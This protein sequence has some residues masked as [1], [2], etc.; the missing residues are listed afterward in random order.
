MEIKPDTIHITASAKVEIQARRADLFIAVRGS[1]VVGGNEAMKKAKEVSALVDEL[2]GAGIKAE[3]IH[4]EGVS[5]ET[6]SGVLLKSSSATYRLR[7]RCEDLEK[8]PETLDIVSAQKNAALERVA[9]KYN[10]EGARGRGLESAL[11]AAKL[12]AQKVA[13]ALGVTLLGVYSFNENAFDE[14]SP[15]PFQPQARMMKARQDAAEPSLA[16]DIQHGKT[17]QVN[18]EIEYR[19][20]GFQGGN[21]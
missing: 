11:V 5:V 1:S 7:V 4:L 15:M 14:E 3:H 13:D 17:I 8:L 2:T 19:V 6:S 20:S 18:V 10:D 9:W 21:A 12:K 16:M